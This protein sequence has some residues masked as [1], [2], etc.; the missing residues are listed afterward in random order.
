MKDV[1]SIGVQS[2]VTTSNNQVNGFQ[3]VTL[4]NLVFM[5]VVI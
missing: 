2:M 4:T 1:N 5:F 3:T